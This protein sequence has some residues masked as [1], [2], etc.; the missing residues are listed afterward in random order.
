MLCCLEFYMFR[1]Q[2]VG[3][4]QIFGQGVGGGPNENHSIPPK[5]K[6]SI[7]KVFH[8][9]FGLLNTGEKKSAFSHVIS[10]YHRFQKLAKRKGEIVFQKLYFSVFQRMSYI[11]C[12]NLEH[13]LL[14]IKS[15]L[16]FQNLWSVYLLKVWAKSVHWNNNYSLES[17]VCLSTIRNM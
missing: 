2:I 9:R 14:L 4:L 1:Y 11:P 12:L 7:F 10:F 15:F 5:A 13:S 8:V 16:V 3:T 17:Y 6:S